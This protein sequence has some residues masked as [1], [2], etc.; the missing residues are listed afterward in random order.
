MNPDAF[1]VF[2]EQYLALR[3]A[4]GRASQ[5]NPTPTRAMLSFKEKLLRNFFDFWSAR[6]C[7][8]PITS[9]LA[10]D[11]VSEGSD[12]GRPYRDR[13]RLFTIRRFLEHLRASEPATETPE[14]IFRKRPRRNPRLLSD[15]EIFRLMEAPGQLRLVSPLRRLTLSTFLGLLASTGLRV[16][17]ALRLKNEDAR[18]DAEPPHLE[19]HNSKFGKSRVVVLHASAADRLRDYAK[20]R[21]TVLGTRSAETF[22]TSQVGKP[23]GYNTTRITFL[24]LLRHA[25]ITSGAGERRATFH[26]FRHNFAVKR[27]T[28]WHRAGKNVPELLPHLTVYLGHLNPRDTYWYVT[29]TPELLEAASVLF[30]AHQRKGASKS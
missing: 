8:W 17:E 25:G 20:Q 27:L 24:R 23:L 16:G 15:R 5:N 10:L 12:P 19:I 18:L 13:H 22:F 30:D 7:R 11:W 3:R 4:V 26:S 1:R 2:L 28:L 21:T 29:A 9:A 6:G 14:N